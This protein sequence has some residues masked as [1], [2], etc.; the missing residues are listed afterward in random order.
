MT[1]SDPPVQEHQPKK[2]KKVENGQSD[3]RF[4]KP[5]PRIFRARGSRWYRNGRENDGQEQELGHRRQRLAVCCRRR[6]T[7]TANALAGGKTIGRS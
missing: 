6:T 5:E 7:R 4:A 1:A 2:I 3:Q